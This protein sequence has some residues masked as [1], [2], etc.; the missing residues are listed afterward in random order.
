LIL[1]KNPDHILTLQHALA[2]YERM[3]SQ[4]HPTYLLQLRVTVMTAK[5]GQDKAIMLLTIVSM[6]V[7]CNLVMIGMFPPFTL[8]SCIT[9]SRKS[10]AG[11]LSMNCNVP[12]NVKEPFGR[13]N[14]FGIVLALVFVITTIFLS[15]V[16][17]WWLQAMRR[18]RAML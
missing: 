18:R 8:P 14:A 17:R 9:T 4:S 15:I 11:V 16:R 12:T 3:L 7:L 13:Y 1:K 6:A 2:H 10:S 5:S